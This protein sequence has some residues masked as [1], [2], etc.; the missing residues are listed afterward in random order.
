MDALALQRRPG[1][2]FDIISVVINICL[3]TEL[4]YRRNKIAEKSAVI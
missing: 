1:L 4:D 3:P 2:R